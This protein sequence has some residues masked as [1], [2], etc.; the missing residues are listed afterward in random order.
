[1]SWSDWHWLCS[2]R[3]QVQTPSRPSRSLS[4][5]ITRVVRRGMHIFIYALDNKSCLHF[6][7]CRKYI[8]AW[9]N[10]LDDIYLHYRFRKSRCW[11]K[12]KFIWFHNEVAPSSVA[13]NRKFNCLCRCKQLV[14]VLCISVNRRN[15]VSWIA[16]F[17]VAFLRN[18]F[19]RSSLRFYHFTS[20]CLA[21]L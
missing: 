7:Y 1:M 10:I 18:V 17:Q 15:V 2:T 9:R 19:F 8:S 20:R 21:N 16:F 13:S 14:Y 3:R 5:S 12:W 11:C 4:S 6:S